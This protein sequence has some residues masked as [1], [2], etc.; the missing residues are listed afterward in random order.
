MK[1]FILKLIL[2]LLLAAPFAALPW[3]WF[4]WRIEQV[5]QMNFNVQQEV[6]LRKL[7]QRYP[8]PEVIF[9]GDSRAEKQLDPRVFFNSGTEAVNLA[10]ASG[11]LWSQARLLRRAGLAHKP[12]VFLISTSLF[13]INDGAIEKGYFSPE[14]FFA[15]TRWE[16]IRTFK[17]AYFRVA[18]RM[19]QDAEWAAANFDSQVA[20][21]MASDAEI[22]ARG[23]LQAAQDVIRCEPLNMDS[24]HSVHPWYKN[25]QLQGAKWRLFA[26]AIHELATWPGTFIIFNPPMSPTYRD[27]VRGSYVDRAEQAFSSQVRELIAGLP[28]VHFVDLYSEV[29]PA[30]GDAA[31]AD[32]VHMNI[33]GAQIFTRY[34]LNRLASEKRL[35]SSGSEQSQ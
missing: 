11:D 2:I 7:M 32:T 25:I 34:W 5:P 16:R 12:L 17:M 29:N 31:F 30:L 28:N 8:H 3:L 27:C 23:Y 26:A 1:T 35:K 6:K 4:E 15:L 10:T 14:Q 9:A 20:Q 13:Q 18:R 22:A 24:S 21:L 19:L 33:D